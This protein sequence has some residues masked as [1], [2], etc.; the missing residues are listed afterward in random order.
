MM[1]ERTNEWKKGVNSAVHENF[2]WLKKE[3][4]M[5]EGTETD[6]IEE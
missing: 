5:T 2:T 3:V 1:K 6:M 4:G